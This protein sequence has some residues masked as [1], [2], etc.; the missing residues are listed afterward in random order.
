MWLIWFRVRHVLKY[1]FKITYTTCS[2]AA[3]IN[4]DPSFLL[5]T[6]STFSSA[7]S[8]WHVFPPLTQ[9]VCFP[10]LGTRSMFSRPWH[11]KYV[12]PPLAQ[13]VC[14][15]APGTSCFIPA[16]GKS[17]MYSYTSCQSNGSPF[18]HQLHFS[19]D[20]HSLQVLIA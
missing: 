13:E 7:W 19:G 11:K 6:S 2:I 10:A 4:N 3:L 14:F 18:C 1:W 15:S 20:C 8:K 12:F 17:S 9:E 16:N 5:D